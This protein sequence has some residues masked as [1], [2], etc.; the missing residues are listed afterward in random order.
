MNDTG[1]EMSR[2]YIFFDVNN[3]IHC[4]LSFWA[5]PLHIAL[6]FVMNTFLCS[7]DD[8]SLSKNDLITST[9]IP[10]LDHA[11]LSIDRSG[12]KMFAMATK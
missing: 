9:N 2:Q 5:S 7:A 1:K 4:Y 6:K 12:S 3:V 11:N 8:W 10:D